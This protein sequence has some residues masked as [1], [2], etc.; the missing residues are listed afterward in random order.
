MRSEY[1]RYINGPDVDQRLCRRHLL[2]MNALLDEL[3]QINRYQRHFHTDKS[4]S[5]TLRLDE[6]HVLLA[7]V[8][9]SY[10]RY[11]SG[12]LIGRA[13]LIG[14]SEQ[15][16]ETELKLGLGPD[17]GP[18]KTR[19]CKAS[20]GF[21]ADLDSRIHKKSDVYIQVGVCLPNT[22]HSNSLKDNR[23]LILRPILYARLYS[24]KTASRHK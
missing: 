6:R 16:L 4:N 13:D 5:S 24:H 18:T 19:Y 7:R 9:D 3:E 8:L 14:S 20:F 21:N 17:E 15:C 22:C 11:E 1:R 12:V 2:R 23:H 10:G